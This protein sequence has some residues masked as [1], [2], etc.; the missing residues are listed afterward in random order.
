L[1]LINHLNL[2]LHYTFLVCHIINVSVILQSNISE[3]RDL[4]VYG[5]VDSWILGCDN[6]PDVAVCHSY[7]LSNSRCNVAR[8]MGS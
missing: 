7:Q 8:G 6:R 3:L 1:Y 4:Y 2:G 5:K